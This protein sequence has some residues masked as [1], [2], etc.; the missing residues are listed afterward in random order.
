VLRWMSLARTPATRQRRI[1]HI[2]QA[3]GERERIKHF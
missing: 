3:C 1:A 2:V